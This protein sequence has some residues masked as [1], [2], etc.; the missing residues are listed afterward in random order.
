[1][2]CTIDSTSALLTDISYFQMKP[3][4]LWSSRDGFTEGADSKILDHFDLSTE[5]AMIPSTFLSHAGRLLPIEYLC[6]DRNDAQAH[7]YLHGGE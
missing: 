7:L 2:A 4:E 6:L 1:M 5:P 3:T